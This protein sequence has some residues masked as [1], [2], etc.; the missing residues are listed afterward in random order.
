MQSPKK[1]VDRNDNQFETKT[2]SLALDHD[3]I[4]KISSI[5]TNTKSKHTITKKNFSPVSISHLNNR[6]YA[7][8]CH[9]L[10]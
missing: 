7:P 4:S 9:A 6:E 10:F 5:M 1:I 2:L 3:I 8:S